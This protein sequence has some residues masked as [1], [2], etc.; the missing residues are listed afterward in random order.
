[1]DNLLKKTFIKKW[2][3][4]ENMFENENFIS[5]FIFNIKFSFWKT[6]F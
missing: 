6:V 4:R 2:M 1:M 5:L 3:M